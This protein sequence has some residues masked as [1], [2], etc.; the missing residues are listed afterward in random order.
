MEITAIKM[1]RPKRLLLSYHYFKN[2]DLSEF[3]KMLGYKPIIFIDS[4][5]YSAYTSG[6]PIKF[7]KF[8]EYLQ[9][10][11]NAPYIKRYFCLDVIG[12]SQKTFETWE[13]MRGLG[14]NPIPVFHYMEDEEYLKR[15]LA[16]GETYIALGGTVPIKSKKEVAEWA[17]LISW[18]YPAKYHLLGSASR[19]ILDE[20][21]LFSAD[22]STWAQS[23]IFGRPEH[24]PGKDSE[25]RKLRAIYNLKTMMERYG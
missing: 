20:V 15:Y 10:P 23:A 4:G 6:R 11:C 17:R 19:I 9:K 8:I 25:S 5:A 1:W 24:I 14:L 16:A 2:V 7:D 3:V 18:Q 12:D 22:A 21:D 13:E